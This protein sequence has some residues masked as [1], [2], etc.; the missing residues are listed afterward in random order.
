M[1][2]EVEARSGHQFQILSEMA[3]LLQEYYFGIEWDSRGYNPGLAKPAD[4][5]GKGTHLFCRY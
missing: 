3:G 2:S 1:T 4:L 5:K